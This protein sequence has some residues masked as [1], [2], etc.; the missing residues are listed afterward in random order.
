MHHALSVAR[1]RLIP[2]GIHIGETSDEAQVRL[3][4]AAL[5][6]FVAAPK[7]TSNGM[8]AFAVLER[9]ALP[10]QRLARRLKSSTYAS[11]SGGRPLRCDVQIICPSASIA[12]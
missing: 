1:A 3:A 4:L 12:S 6:H 9:D 7:H 5:R 10:V 2:S 8:P 11:P